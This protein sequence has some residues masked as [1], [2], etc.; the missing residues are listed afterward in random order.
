MRDADAVAR[1]TRVFQRQFGVVRDVF[2]GS[3]HLLAVGRVEDRVQLPFA[4]A[5]AWVAE[6]AAVGSGV[7]GLE[8]RRQYDAE[9]L[10]ECMECA[11]GGGRWWTVSGHG[12][13]GWANGRQPIVDER[14]YICLPLPQQVGVDA[15]GHRNRGH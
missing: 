2:A 8:N 15:V 6:G 9:L 5:A 1:K 13:E 7:A 3:L 12:D 4:V 14:V 10:F 11:V